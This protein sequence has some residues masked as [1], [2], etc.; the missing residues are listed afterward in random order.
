MEVKSVLTISCLGHG[1]RLWSL[2][3]SGTIVE[4]LISW[5]G[6]QIKME[7]G[8]VYPSLCSS[9]SPWSWSKSCIRWNMG[10]IKLKI[11]GVWVQRV[12]EITQSNRRQRQT[13]RK[14][15]QTHSHISENQRQSMETRLRVRGLCVVCDSGNH[16]NFSQVLKCRH[17]HIIAVDPGWTPEH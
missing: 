10:L 7:Q 17:T 2:G 14:R 1:T 3:Q 12:Q 11:H 9:G 8:V 6:R 4:M 15:N 16:L 13:K 5:S